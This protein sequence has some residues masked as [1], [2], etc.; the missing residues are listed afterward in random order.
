MSEE[1]QGI[2]ATISPQK[3]QL[4]KLKFLVQAVVPYGSQLKNCNSI[5]EL[6]KLM[7]E[8]QALQRVDYRYA[9]SLL[10]HMLVVTGYN[11]DKILQPH[12]H[13]KFD[14][15]ETAPLLSLFYEPLLHLADKLLQNTSNYKRLL[16]SIDKNKLSKLKS[17]ISSPLDL[18]QSMICKGTLDP[19]N[20]HSL[21]KFVTILNAAGLGDEAQLVQQSL[22]SGMNHYYYSI[23]RNIDRN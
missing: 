13:E 14:L 16:N 11:Q 9:V 6:Y 8:S 10:R 18:L 20:P 12:C 2:L 15:A 4:S 1:L 21:I 17:D 5:P 23:A 19:S 7:R 22:Y 3:D